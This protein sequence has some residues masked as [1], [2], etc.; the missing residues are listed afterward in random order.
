MKWRNFQAPNMQESLT[1]ARAALVEGNE[2]PDAVIDRVRGLR[3]G[4]LWG[5]EV[6]LDQLMLGLADAPRPASPE[7]FAQCFQILQEGGPQVYALEIARE[8]RAFAK[9]LKASG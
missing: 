7:R 4:I 2:V 6:A 3:D 8:Q 1:A 5:D 9:L